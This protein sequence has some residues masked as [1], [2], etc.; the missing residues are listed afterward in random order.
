VNEIEHTDKQRA[1]I[2]APTGIGKTVSVLYPSLLNFKKYDR[3]FYLTAKNSGKEIVDDT[4]VSL[5]DSKLGLKSIVL[6]AKEKICPM[7]QTICTPDSC[8]LAKGYYDKIKAA[9]MDSFMSDEKIFNYDY[10]SKIS[11]KYQICPF[12]YQLDLSLFCDLIVGDY[13]YVFD[14]FVY[15]KRYMDKD[16][17][18]SLLLV[19]EGHN[20]LDRCRSMY[21]ISWSIEDLENAKKSLKKV[22]NS[23]IKTNLNKIKKYLLSFNDLFDDNGI[24]SVQFFEQSFI[25]LLTKL[26]DNFTSLSNTDAKLITK[27]YKK[28]FTDVN[29]FLKIYELSY[30][31]QYFIYYF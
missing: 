2:E 31:D 4:V 7:N 17:S 18:Q 22:K 26:V 21:S 3:I 28:L 25:K 15:L 14:P 30:T 16:T 20:L 9:L 6:T 8:P 10:I 19:D 13:N 23:A 29:K 5:I 27:E 1:L 11:Y 12:E 24:L